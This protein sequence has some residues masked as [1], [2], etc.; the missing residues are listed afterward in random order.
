VTRG[1]RYAGRTSDGADRADLSQPRD[2][3]KEARHQ[4]EAPARQA[5]CSTSLARRV[6]VRRRA[7]PESTKPV[8]RVF[9][10]QG[11]P[12]RQDSWASRGD[13]YFG[14]FI[15]IAPRGARPKRRRGAKSSEKTSISRRAGPCG[16][17]AKQAVS[18]LIGARLAPD[19]T[20]IDKSPRSAFSPAGRGFDPFLASQRLI[21]S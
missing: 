2:L 9:K 19:L 7:A 1:D 10:L 6:G 14:R 13:L 8:I 21:V 18:C 3:L 4:P 11:L 16:G 12:G 17:G 15:Y 20:H 5:H